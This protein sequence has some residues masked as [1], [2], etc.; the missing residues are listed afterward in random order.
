VSA[1]AGLAILMIA[2]VAVACSL[3]A[4]EIRARG[5]GGAA[6]TVYGALTARRARRDHRLRHP[7]AG[8]MSDDPFTSSRPRPVPT[9]VD[10]LRLRLDD[11]AFDVVAFALEAVARH[12]GYG[13][14]RALPGA[15][16]WIDELRRAGKR[17]A[18]VSSAETGAAAT[19]IAGIRDRFEAVVSG[20]RSVQTLQHARDE[21][22]AT[23]SRAVAV[24]VDP[25][26]VVAA[27]EAGFGKAVAVAR[28]WA[29]AEE[30]RR[31][32]AD[33]VVADLQ[34]LLGVVR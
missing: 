28:D 14:V 25:A 32:G 33:V 3:K 11:D 10:A 22:G 31:S 23:P 7:S 9:V 2:T 27:R 24:D 8:E 20:R 17:C 12:L 6:V 18:M 34:E 4:S 16:A 29:S 15:V 21:L 13:D 30:L 26:G 5:D 1:I 19:E